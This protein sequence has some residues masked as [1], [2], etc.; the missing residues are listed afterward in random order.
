MLQSKIWF[1]LAVG[2]STIGLCWSPTAAQALTFT[3]GGVLTASTPNAN[4]FTYQLPFP[5]GVSVGGRPVTVSSATITGQ[6]GQGAIR[7]AAGGSLNG[8]VLKLGNFNLA[9]SSLGVID[10]NPSLN[11]FN[12][13][14]IF[15]NT[16]T[17][18][19]ANSANVV[20]AQ[21]L[22]GSF[23]NNTT[24]ATNQVI[25]PASVSLNNGI[26][27]GTPS[28][29]IGALTNSRAFFQVFSQTSFTN[30]APA[31]QL[32]INAQLSDLVLAPQQTLNLPS[33]AC[34]VV[35]EET[36]HFKLTQAD[37]ARACG[38]TGGEGGTVTVPESSSVAGLLAVGAVAAMTWM[39]RR[40]K[41]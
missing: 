18:P 38:E 32:T 39:R 6:G 35:A 30:G 12:V 21:L 8:V 22:S 33:S 40:I 16:F 19:I 4:N 25:F 11:A 37:V 27:V 5:V 13:F 41:L 14:A 26:S 31:S 24:G 17:V 28:L 3:L 10:P 1:P 9:A 34:M 36:E 29:A 7:T 20:V 2:V 23:P 15:S